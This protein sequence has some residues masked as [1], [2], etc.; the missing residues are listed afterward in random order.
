VVLRDLID[1]NSPVRG[2]GT[3]SLFG[4]SST[5]AALELLPRSRSWRAI[6]ATF[7]LRPWAYSRL[8]PPGPQEL[9]FWV[10]FSDFGS[11]GNV[12]RSSP[13]KAT[14]PSAVGRWRSGR[15]HPSGKPSPCPVKVAIMNPGW[16]FRSLPDPDP[17]PGPSERRANS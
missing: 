11:G 7:W 15:G 4:F 6:R 1:A 17:N 3:L 12:S 13:F 5:E 9:W 10:H 16:W 8:M 2:T 14:A